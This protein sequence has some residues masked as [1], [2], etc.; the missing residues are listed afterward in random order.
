MNTQRF[1]A[2]TRLATLAC[3]LLVISGTSQAML[4]LATRPLTGTMMRLASITLSQTTKQWTRSV[5]QPVATTYAKAFHYD[6]GSSPLAQNEN[7]Q[8]GKSK[9]SIQTNSSLPLLQEQQPMQSGAIT[10]VKK[11]QAQMKKKTQEKFQ[12]Q[13]QKR[14]EK[15][16]AELAQEKKS[17]QEAQQ[18][19]E[20]ELETFEKENPRK[21]WSHDI[22]NKIDQLKEWA[23]ELHQEEASAKEAEIREKKIFE[24]ESTDK[25]TQQEQ[26]EV[27]RLYY[28]QRQFL[29]KRAWKDYRNN[30]LLNDI[31]RIRKYGY[32]RYI[33]EHIK[34]EEKRRM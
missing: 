31:H 1:Q 3:T 26:K 10:N 32:D 15:I 24:F 27:D 12:E 6:S 28:E 14:F 21:Y 17:L 11:H 7:N 9:Q 18:K 13:Q 4:R 20:T 16:F 5:Q 29:M 34:A 23:Y 30:T 2:R 22:K 19:L 33:F 25:H 8:H